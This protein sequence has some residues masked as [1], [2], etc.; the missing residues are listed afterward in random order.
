ML[1]NLAGEKAYLVEC[2]CS[3]GAKGILTSAMSEWDFLYEKCRHREE[4]GLGPLVL[5]ARNN[6]CIR[7]RDKN[8][9]RDREMPK[10]GDVCDLQVESGGPIR[11]VVVATVYRSGL[12]PVVY[13]GEDGFEDEWFD[14]ATWDDVATKTGNV[15]EE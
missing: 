2:T 12:K 13:F 15:F 4:L 3:I 1:T 8:A 10:P 7:C 14:S 9:E 6:F 11:R 5:D